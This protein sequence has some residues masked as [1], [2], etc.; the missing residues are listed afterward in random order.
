MPAGRRQHIVPQMMIRRST[1]DDGRVI[2]LYKPTVKIATHRKY[3]RQI[4]WMDNFYRDCLLDFDAEI[5]RKVKAF[6]I[7]RKK[8]VLPSKKEPEQLYDKF[9]GIV[10]KV[11]QVI[12][13]M[14]MR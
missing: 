11:A 2:E 4:L 1:G 8:S 12:D 5:L 13:K 6:R 10:E 3:P 14:D 7:Q 9:M